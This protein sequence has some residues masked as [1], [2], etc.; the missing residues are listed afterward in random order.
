M[1]F[2]CLIQ[3]ELWA[4]FIGFISQEKGAITNMEQQEAAEG[5]LKVQYGRA[6]IFKLLF[7]SRSFLIVL[8]TAQT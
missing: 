4:D 6:R 5:G 3:E 1:P 7:I 2:F 8:F